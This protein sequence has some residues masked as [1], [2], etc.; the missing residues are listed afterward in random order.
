MADVDE[1]ANKLMKARCRLMTR[2]PWYGH[3]AMSIQWFASDMSWVDD[4]GQRTIGMRIS[5]KGMVQAYST[6]SGS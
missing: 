2:Q 6:L 1:A 5:S 4:P 3:M